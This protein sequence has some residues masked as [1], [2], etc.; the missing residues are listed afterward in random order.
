MVN[1]RKKGVKNSSSIVFIGS[2]NKITIKDFKFDEIKKFYFL[3]NYEN[4]CILITIT[5]IVILI[6]CQLRSLKPDVSASKLDQSDAFRYYKRKIILKDPGKSMALLISASLP[7]VFVYLP[8]TEEK[9]EQWLQDV[10]YTYTGNERRVETIH[11]GNPIEFIHGTMARILGMVN[12]CPASNMSS[13][14]VNTDC[15]NWDI[16]NVLKRLPEPFR[17]KKELLI[18]RF[19]ILVGETPPTFDEFPYTGKNTVDGGSIIENELWCGKSP[20]RNRKFD[21]EDVTIDMEAAKNY[22]S[23]IELEKLKAAL[24]IGKKDLINKLHHKIKKAMKQNEESHKQPNSTHRSSNSI[25]HF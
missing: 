18:E 25:L 11:E 6:L 14:G 13:F 21:K 19:R 2:E 17:F 9:M 23:H 8:E 24:K 1:K 16:E 20:K 4:I 5:I 7:E 12:S 22:L 10:F 15:V 3:N